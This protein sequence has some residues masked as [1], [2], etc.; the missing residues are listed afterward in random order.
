VKVVLIVIIW[1][2][3]TTKIVH[4]CVLITQF[5]SSIRHAC[6]EIIQ[7]YSNIEPCRTMGCCIDVPLSCLFYFIYFILFYFFHSN[8]KINHTALFIMPNL[9][10]MWSFIRIRFKPIKMRD[11]CLLANFYM[12]CDRE[13]TLAAWYT[14]R[15]KSG[16]PYFYEFA[17]DSYETS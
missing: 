6:L 15:C 17:T 5:N 8:K 7:S 10:N 2:D 12:M 13:T 14:F 1:I 9:V 3:Q 4:A 11:S 16:V